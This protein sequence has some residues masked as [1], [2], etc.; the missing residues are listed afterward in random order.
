MLVNHNNFVLKKPFV[1][2][3]TT[4]GQSEIRTSTW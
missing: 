1:Q 2:Y 3:Y 4:P